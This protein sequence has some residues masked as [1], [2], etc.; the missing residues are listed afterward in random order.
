MHYMAL[1]LSG[2]PTRS[3]AE[4]R[5]VTQNARRKT[6]DSN[7]TE[8]IHIKSY[9]VTRPTYGHHDTRVH[10][11]F[12]PQRLVCKSKYL[13]SAKK[14][15]IG[16]SKPP[17]RSPP[18]PGEPRPFLRIVNMK[19]L[20]KGS[21]DNN[22]INENADAMIVLNTDLP[23]HRCSSSNSCGRSLPLWYLPQPIKL[24]FYVERIIFKCHLS[25]APCTK[26]HHVWSSFY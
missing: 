16:T 5:V 25:S 23:H 17:R 13:D 14:P 9:A 8:L 4:S 1:R 20:M 21:K 12:L 15:W 7:T 3:S 22:V 26:F 18:C 10:S 24:L 19:P 2:P 11:G 6:H